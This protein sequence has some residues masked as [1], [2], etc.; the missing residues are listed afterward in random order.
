[1]FL[2][3][4]NWDNFNESKYLQLQI[5]RYK[6]NFGYYPES[7]HVDKI[8]RTARKQKILSKEGDK[9]KWSKARQAEERNQWWGEKT[10]L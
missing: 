4:V 2:A 3:H 10:S 8:Y 7:V 5:E 6:E 9:N 1:M